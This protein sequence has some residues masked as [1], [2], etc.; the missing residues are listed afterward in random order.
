MSTNSA[1]VKQ[2]LDSLIQIIHL[3]RLCPFH[4]PTMRVSGRMGARLAL[5]TN[6]RWKAY[7]CHRGRRLLVKTLN[8]SGWESRSGLWFVKTYKKSSH[9]QKVTNP[10]RT[11][12]QA[13]NR[14][15]IKKAQISW[16]LNTSLT[17]ITMVTSKMRLWR[18]SELGFTSR[19]LAWL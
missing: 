10:S 18:M 12:S 4:R 3:R 5:A 14:S 8:S 13:R 11:N 6:C 16:V 17:I 9:M 1:I 19:W 7:R 15:E 2:A